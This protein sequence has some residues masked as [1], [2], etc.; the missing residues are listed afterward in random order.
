MT[1]ADAPT[2]LAAPRGAVIALALGAFAI[3]TSEFMISGLLQN[4][5][6]DLDVSIPTA[7][8]LIAGYAGGVALGGPPMS[9]VTGRLRRKQQILLLLAIF[10]AGNVMCALA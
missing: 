1:F 5:A 4:V 3:G 9:L 2:S 10:I 6:S 8:L 7:G